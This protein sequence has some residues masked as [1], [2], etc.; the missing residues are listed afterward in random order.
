MN[1][2]YLI[3]FLISRNLCRGILP[4]T[5]NL[6]P[7]TPFDWKY[8]MF[9]LKIHISLTLAKDRRKMVLEGNDDF[10]REIEEGLQTREVRR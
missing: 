6:C 5:S 3:V 9:E 7:K 1:Y 10:E 2:V 4:V 8:Q